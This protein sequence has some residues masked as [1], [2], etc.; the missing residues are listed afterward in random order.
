VGAQSRIYH[1]SVTNTDPTADAPVFTARQGDTV[2]LVIHSARPGEL[3]VHAVEE[4][5]LAL[6][7]GGEV[8]LT[9]VAK[10]SGRFAV[11]LHDPDGSMHH[12]AMLEVQPE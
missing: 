2:T 3:H 1:L 6:K 7:P 8:N 12:V 4:S 11:H 10:N 5:A 9:F